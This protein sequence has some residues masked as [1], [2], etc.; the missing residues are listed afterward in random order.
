MFKKTLL[1]GFIVLAAAHSGANQSLMDTY[2]QAVE[3][4][5]TLS[6]ANLTAQSSRE[7]VAS[8]LSAVLPKVSVGAQYSIRSDATEES[9]IP[10][11]DQQA[12]GASL[13]VSQNLFA[14]AAFS[15]YDAL[16]VNAKASEITAEYA[17]QQLIVRV[18]EAYLNAL[19]AK[20]ALE[21]LNAQ[22]EAVSRQFEQTE[23]R[24]DVGLV[25]ITDVLDATATLDETR[26]AL[27]RAESNYDIA[28][29]NLSILTG[30][31]PE[32]ILSIRE[33]VPI[34]MPQQAE[35]QNLI[36]FATTQHPQIIAAERGLEVGQLT[37][38]ARQQENLPTIA[39]T[40]SID[41]SDS[42]GDNGFDNDDETN[43][44]ASVG[45]SISYS[46]FD[47]GA[48][49][50]TIAQQGIANNIAEQNL[51]LLKRSKAVSVS[52]L[53]RTVQADVQ[54]V[55]AQE[56]AL[57]SRE[58]A[59]QATTVGYDVGTRN[60]VEVLD[61]QLN[62][63]NAQTQLNTARYDYLLNLLKLKQEAGQ[64]SLADLES[65]ENYLIQ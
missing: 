36:D 45:I 39:G 42:F 1:S 38:K 65:I 27:I 19:R 4:D 43:W 5:P 14:L 44:S 64:V 33:D 52:N 16:K 20:D 37:L 11:F 47:G 30:S 40:A 60:I 54:N 18:A 49:D 9:I 58:S 8:G 15:A 2:V 46:L 13:S 25:T 53:F 48:S 35:Q 41:Y 32:G 51:T 21:V 34:V 3:N 56:Q 31:T 62:V 50:A 28:L 10:S 23:Q 7:N 59:L 55:S 61:A 12:I 57:K 63:F 22:L 6:I 24:Y 29:Q 26:V 17:Q